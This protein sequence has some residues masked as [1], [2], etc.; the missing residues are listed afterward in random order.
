LSFFFQRASAS[1]AAPPLDATVTA[2]CKQLSALTSQPL[3]VDSV[4][5]HVAAFELHTRLVQ[6]PAYLVGAAPEQL[7]GYVARIEELAEEQ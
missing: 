7:R 2:Y 4:R 1:G 3:S 6:W 5:R